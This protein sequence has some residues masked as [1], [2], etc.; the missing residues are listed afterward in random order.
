MNAA[1]GLYRGA[2][3]GIV[4][5]WSGQFGYQSRKS[6]P[7]IKKVAVFLVLA[8]IFLGVYW[9]FSGD[10]EPDFVL[11]DGFVLL[12]DGESLAGWSVIG[13]QSSFAAE[14]DS[15]V[16][17]HGPGE[18]TFLRTDK[19]FADFTLK[20]QMRWD[21]PGNSGVLFR[22]QQRDGNGRAY[23]Y[24]YEL[25]APLIAR[26]GHKTNSL[27]KEIFVHRLNGWRRLLLPKRL[28]NSRSHFARAFGKSSPNLHFPKT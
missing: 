2:F 1:A 3:S 15:I 23:G 24:Q 11:E 14:G 12:Y 21:E 20:M 5:K 9:Q 17:R 8:L 4:A 26:S 19:T 18:N 10:A 13:G 28:F 27:S 25:D 22:A 7:M 6:P 16:G